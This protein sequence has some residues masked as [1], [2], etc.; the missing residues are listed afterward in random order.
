MDCT[1][2]GQKIPFSVQKAAKQMEHMKST[3][4]CIQKKKKK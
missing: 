2:Q 1:Y 4:K 3:Q